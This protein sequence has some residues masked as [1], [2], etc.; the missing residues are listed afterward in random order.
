MTKAS[1][2]NNFYIQRN[3][4]NWGNET[5]VNWATEPDYK[6]VV[7]V[8]G[9][10]GSSMATFGAFNYEFRYRDEYK[11]HDV[12]FFEY[13]SLYTQI[14]NSALQFLEFLKAIH[15]AL[16]NVVKESGL[17]IVRNKQYSEIVVICHSLGAV[18]ARLAFVEGYEN[19]DIAMLNKCK[20]VL[21]APAH[22]G[23]NNSIAKFIDLPIYIGVLGAVARLVVLTLDQLLKPE[24]IIAPLEKKCVDIIEKDGIKSFTI[25]RKVIWAGPERVVINSKFGKDPKAIEYKKLRVGHTQIC[26]PTVKFPQPMSEVE[27]V[28]NGNV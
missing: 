10:S 3:I 24:I 2:V 13:D 9:F 14:G 27:E 8:H 23:A 28:L 5:F 21:F 22:K 12:Y 15:D 25:A 6:A 7:F 16:P 4:A 19:G 1:Q 18:I 17:D 26:K 20:L 11:G